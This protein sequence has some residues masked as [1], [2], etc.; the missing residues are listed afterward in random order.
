MN[1]SFQMDICFWKK[2]L[3][4]LIEDSVSVFYHMYSQK[5]PEKK[6]Q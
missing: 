2:A 5:N 6:Y 3:L 1:K 4:F